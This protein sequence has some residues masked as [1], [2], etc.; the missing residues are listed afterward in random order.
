[1]LLGELS[2]ASCEG[3]S[4]PVGAD[5]FLTSSPAASPEGTAPSWTEVAN[6]YLDLTQWGPPP[7]SEIQW[8]TLRNVIELADAS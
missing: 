3:T 2:S 4:Q 1:M 8:V 5:H 6:G 7:W